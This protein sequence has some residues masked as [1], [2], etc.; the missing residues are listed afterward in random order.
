MSEKGNSSAR[1]LSLATV[2]GIIFIV[3]KLTGSLKWSWVWVLSPFWVSWG[4]FL[5][6]VTVYFLFLRD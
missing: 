3:L 5:L 6:L 2:L 1:G 4:L